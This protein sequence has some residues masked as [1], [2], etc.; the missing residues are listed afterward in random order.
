M[1]QS[2]RGKGLT[3]SVS[4]FPLSDLRWESKKL[5]FGSFFKHEINKQVHDPFDEENHSA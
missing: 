4:P 5:F 1:E 3:E 2:K